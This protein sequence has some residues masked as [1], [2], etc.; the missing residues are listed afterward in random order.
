MNKRLADWLNDTKRTQKW[1]AG[2]LGVREG[3]VSAW[4]N[5]GLPHARTIGRIAE[6][7][8]GAVPADSWFDSAAQQES[9]A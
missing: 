6:I 8:G 1:L 3:T 5:G 7:T 2:E 9:A 4:M